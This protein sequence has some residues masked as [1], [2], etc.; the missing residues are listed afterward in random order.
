VDIFDL[1]VGSTQPQKIG[2]LTVFGG[3]A[4]GLLPFANGTHT[5]TASMVD[6]VGNP[7]SD[8]VSGAMFS[9][10]PALSAISPPQT[11]LF[12]VASSNFNLFLTPPTP[13][14]IQDKIPGGD[15]EADFYVTVSNAIG[16]VAR[17]IYQGSDLVPPQNITADPQPV[18]IVSAVLPQ[19]S[20]GLLQFRATDSVGNQTTSSANV[21]VDVIPP[22]PSTLTKVVRDGGERTATVDLVWTPSGD[23]GLSGTPAGYDLRWGTNVTLPDG[24][25]ESDST[26]FNGARTRQVTL[27]DG[28]LLPANMTSYALTP[29]P[30]LASYSIMVRARDGIGNDAPYVS[31]PN[32]SNFLSQQALSN[33]DVDA[34]TASF[35][36]AYLSKGDFNGDGADDLV[37]GAAQGP[38]RPGSVWVYYGTPS[39]PPAPPF[40]T[41]PQQL[42]PSDG[43]LGNFGLDFAVGNVTDGGLPDLLVSQNVWSGG[44]GRAFLY[45]GQYGAQ[46]GK[47]VEFRGTL[48]VSGSF[49]GACKIISDINRD[50]MDE[51]LISAHRENSN[52]GRVYLF[53]GRSLAQWQALQTAQDL[54]GD[55]TFYVP[56][57]S[58][59]RIF[60]GDGL[61]AAPDPFFGRLRG[62]A[63]VGNLG[64]AG[65]VSFTV[66]ASL[67]TVNRV[68]LHSG[69]LVNSRG[70]GGIIAT[71]DATQVLSQ[72]CAT[73][74]GTL[75]G[76]GHDAFGNFN[77]VGGPANDLIVTLPRDNRIYILP[78][79]S[80]T[81]FNNPP[82][83]ISSNT[84]NFG[85]S[86]AYGDI[87]MDGRLDIVV[88]ENQGV[89]QSLWI[90]Y[91]Q[92]KP[93]SEFDPTA[94][95][96]FSQSRL[97][98]P[99]TLG[100][101]V[102]VGDF[103]GDGKP[104][105][106]AG[107][108][109]DSPGKIRVSY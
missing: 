17:L 69:A 85:Q 15:A 72:A 88:G 19:K 52:V 30:P 57:S 4:T 13:G 29:L 80:P 66:P 108:V 103:N 106:A 93:L 109:L 91:N 27:P 76:F 58:A 37:V 90:F 102:A 46:L 71:T 12:Y 70:P 31:Q 75:S 48:G 100:I 74:L 97:T 107:D 81:G 24:G 56:T 89:N 7:A 94:G 101:G 51:I 5:I 8:S 33:P 83:T 11:N 22:A 18:S 62:Y 45:F 95:T 10:C 38:G 50:G 34:G 9:G 2:T 53:Y 16:G 6:A 63:S 40:T 87:N 3:V 55:T 54:P 98:G 59:D 14:Y 36:G 82:L 99:F 25:I 78:D 35:Y 86:L 1:P 92:G 68:F 32:L 20:S 26:F 42:T 79:G 105:I 41:P 96:G 21:V 61:P 67:D 28:G 44:R 60:T 84:G 73:P 43:A 23:D 64:G 47:V 104:D 49:G 65:G 77:I 39:T